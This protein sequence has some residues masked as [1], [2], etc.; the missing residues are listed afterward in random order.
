VIA[1]SGLFGFLKNYFLKIYQIHEQIFL[2]QNFKK[3]QNP[4]ESGAT[5][6]ESKQTAA[7]IPVKVSLRGRL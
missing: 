4:Y 1:S 7:D 5:F 3:I 6:Q 2:L